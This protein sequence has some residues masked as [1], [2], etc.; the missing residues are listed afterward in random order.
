MKNYL[1]TILVYCL[2]VLVKNC[3]LL[4]LFYFQGVHLILQI[5]HA[6][7]C[8]V[9]F[10]EFNFRCHYNLVVKYNF[11]PFPFHLPSCHGIF[12]V[13]LNPN[14]FG[15]FCSPL[16]FLLDLHLNVLLLKCYHLY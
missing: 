6:A 1:Q 5:V 2:D 9:S 3:Y 14:I 8:Q 11:H 16:E 10:H 7:H 13:D 4:M 15:S 12:L